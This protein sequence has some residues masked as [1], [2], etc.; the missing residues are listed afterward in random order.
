MSKEPDSDELVASR[1]IFILKL[2][3]EHTHSC[4]LYTGD[5]PKEI[6]DK[7]INAYSKE[8]EKKKRL[9]EIILILY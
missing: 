2:L 7:L 4:E 8:L 9:K 5:I 3:K 1:K 6:K